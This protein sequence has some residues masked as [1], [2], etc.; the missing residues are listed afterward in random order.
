MFILFFMMT[1]CFITL[2]CHVNM[3]Q[4]RSIRCLIAWLQ[5]SD[6]GIV[7]LYAYNCSSHLQLLIDRK[8]TTFPI[9]VHLEN[10]DREGDRQKWMK[11]RKRVEVGK[12]KSKRQIRWKLTFP[13]KLGLLNPPQKILDYHWYCL[14]P[15][16]SC[17]NRKLI[18]EV[19][20]C[21]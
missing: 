17:V 18:C 4:S 20:H 12:K 8:E 15:Q 14:P 21:I 5:S 13:W 9:Y 1:V 6:I 16:P 3:W 2:C 10:F 11:E 19:Y 7:F